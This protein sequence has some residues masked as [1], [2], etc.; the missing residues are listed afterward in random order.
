M[1]ITRTHT[2]TRTYT[3][4]EFADPYK[5]CDE[6][7]EWV[8]GFRELPGMPNHPC[9]HHAGYTDLCPSWG[10]VDGCQCH[11]HLGHVPHGSPS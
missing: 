7:G 1:T 5:T 4:V 11:A 3:V 8:V 9:G 2:H 10:P 6:C